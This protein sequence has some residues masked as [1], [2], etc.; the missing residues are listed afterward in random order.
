[1]IR[2]DVTV[3]SYGST[4]CGMRVLPN[5]AAASGPT[6]TSCGQPLS[7]GGLRLRVLPR[8]R[9]ESSICFTA[10]RRARGFCTR[11][12]ASRPAPSPAR[13]RCGHQVL[14][15]LFGRHE[16]VLHRRDAILA[17]VLDELRRFNAGELLHPLEQFRD[18]NPCPFVELNLGDRTFFWPEEDRVHRVIRFVHRLDDD[19][20]HLRQADELGPEEFVGGAIPL[21]ERFLGHPGLK[22]RS[23]VVDNDQEVGEDP[24]SSTFST[25][26]RFSPKRS[27]NSPR[28]PPTA[29]GCPTSVAKAG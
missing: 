4:P 27:R 18:R 12:P 16:G 8:R 15:V 25:S 6:P 14:V 24:L 28:A 7:G 29:S 26:F 1:M 10:R 5:S 17:R 23:G 19:V 13:R 22:E 3:S 9:E 2:S 21:D 11:S 20:E